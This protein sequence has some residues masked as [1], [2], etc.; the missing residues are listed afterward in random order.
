MVILILILNNLN[1]NLDFNQLLILSVTL[2]HY[3]LLHMYG[4]VTGNE[5]IYGV[6]HTTHETT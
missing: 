2:K 6:E 1:F 3:P 5:F 4:C